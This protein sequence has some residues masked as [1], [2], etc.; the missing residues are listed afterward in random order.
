MGTMVRTSLGSQ[1]PEKDTTKGDIEPQLKATHTHRTHL[2]SQESIYFRYQKCYTVNPPDTQ[3]NPLPTAIYTF[4]NPNPSR[5]L[6]PLRQRPKPKVLPALLP[7]AI[8][9]LLVK[10]L[11]RIQTRHILGYT[12]ANLLDRLVEVARV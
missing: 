6:T 1:V 10:L 8:P 4:L 9:I 2:H 7:L 5:T 3:S 12:R 11:D